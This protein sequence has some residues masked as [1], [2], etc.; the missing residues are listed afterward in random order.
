M[1]G[2]NFHSQKR[3]SQG[4]AGPIY[5]LAVVIEVQRLGDRLLLIL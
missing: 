5:G 2:L 3:A 1:A 4:Q